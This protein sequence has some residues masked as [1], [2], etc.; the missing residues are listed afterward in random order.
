MRPCP[1]DANKP[2]DKGRGSK[3][4]P[5]RAIAQVKGWELRQEVW[6]GQGAGAAGGPVCVHTGNAELG[7]RGAVSLWRFEEKAQKKAFLHR[8]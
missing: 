7:W 6:V 4:A 8:S 2:A 3:A 1:Y 5:E